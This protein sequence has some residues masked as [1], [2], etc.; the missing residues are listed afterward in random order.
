MEKRIDLT[1]Y[2]EYQTRV[3]G[4]LSERLFRVWLMMQGEKITEEE[5]KLIAPEDFLNAEK[6]QGLSVSVYQL[7]GA[8]C[9]AAISAGQWH[10]FTGREGRSQR[11]V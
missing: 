2:D 9:G 4:F 5:I 11:Y 6:K 7:K 1:G 8:A 3:M 10:T